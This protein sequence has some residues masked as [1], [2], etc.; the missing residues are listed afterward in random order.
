MND[1]TTK[2]IER[3]SM[4]NLETLIDLGGKR[5]IEKEAIEKALEAEGRT[6]QMIDLRKL[7]LAL[8]EIATGYGV[9][10]Q[11]V[12][13]LTGTKN[14]FRAA[15]LVREIA[16][17]DEVVYLIW[18]AAT[19]NPDWWTAKDRIFRA[20]VVQMFVDADYTWDA[21]R[22]HSPL[23][24]KASS[25][26]VLLK[27]KYNVEMNAKAQKAWFLEALKTQTL[28]EIHKTINTGQSLYTGW[29]LF[30]R[31][32]KGLGV[33]ENVPSPTGSKEVRSSA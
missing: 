12:S 16:S 32:L 28:E 3:G 25:L 23:C 26:D 27:V 17:V 22:A 24:T 30:S 9:K 10:K 19:E 8:D 20:R 15:P 1:K 31:S 4:N 29:P 5:G 7:G 11:R 21:A 14:G 33:I 2:F 18:V 6:K 13:Q